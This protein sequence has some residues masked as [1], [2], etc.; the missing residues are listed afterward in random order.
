MTKDQAS[1]RLQELKND[2]DWMKRYMAGDTQAKREFV[3]L[4]TIIG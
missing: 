3:S 2:K 1:A 4:T